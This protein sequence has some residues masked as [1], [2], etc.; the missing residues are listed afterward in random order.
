MLFV[1]KMRIDS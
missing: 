1:W